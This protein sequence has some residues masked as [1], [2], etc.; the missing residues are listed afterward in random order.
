MIGSMNISDILGTDLQTVHPFSFVL[1]L[2]ANPAD[3]VPSLT[4]TPPYTADT[5]GAVKLIN[6]NVECTSCHNPHVQNIDPNTSFLVINNSASALCLACHSTIPSG[7]G[8]GM[9]VAAQSARTSVGIKI[10]DRANPLEG[11][12]TSSHATAPNR[13]AG[14]VSIGA[15][16]V[17]G[18]TV[19]KKASLGSYPTVAQN[20]C[21]SCHTTHKAQSPA[22]LL[23]GPYDQDCIS[24]HAG[25]S[26]VSPAAPDVL[27]EMSLP[28]VGHSFPQANHMHQAS[29]SA[30]LNQNRHATCVDCHNAHSSSH[31]TIFAGPPTLRPS[32]GRVE[33][34]SAADGV[35]VLNPA[36]NQ[37][38]NCLRCHG[39]STGKVVS[40]TFGYAPR[41]A[42]SAGDP[43]NVIPQFSV[44]ATSN[45]PVMR[46][47]CSPFPQPSLLSN[48]LNLDGSTPGRSMGVRILC[49]DCHNSDDNREFG[50]SGPNGPHGS[51]FS[52]ILERRYEFSQASVP[53][54]FITNLF[55]N[56][57]TS[58][59]GGANGGPYA[60]CAK[61]HNL[62]SIL[63]NTSFSEHARHV[64]QDG[65]SCSVCHTAHGMG[66]QA[67]T[68]SGERMVNFDVNV[69]APN[70]NTPIS[71]S[72]AT[73]SCA[74]VCH[75]QAHQLTGAPKG[76]PKGRGK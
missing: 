24:C 51:T 76:K 43:L 17:T 18:E 13:V 21:L 26:N 23:R 69:V 56:P 30:V 64:K 36:L 34:I 68:D 7:T 73:N 9:S 29:E 2:Q 32:Q 4:A 41:R 31:V 33:G 53:G 71:Y 44:I 28:K 39:S 52:H 74:L 63:S 67:G 20:G 25:G 1:P 54:Q 5:T 65:F 38:E 48:M 46:D 49:T 55:Q 42:A 72:R 58:A 70:G 12:K 57:N 19:A 75:N 62:T 47:R 22:S 61:C 45:H 15:Y 3:L 35:T 60:L 40:S 50:G 59:A 66:A 11:W 14:Q 27:A 6:G 10:T 16:P 8:M 37:Y